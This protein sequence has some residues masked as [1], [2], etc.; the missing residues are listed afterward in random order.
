MSR[1]VLVVVVALGLGGCGSRGTQSGPPASQPASGPVRSAAACGADLKSDPL[2][3]GACGRVCPSADRTLPV[4]LKGECRQVC[5]V[6]YGECDGDPATVCETEVL[7]DPCHCFRC[8]A[9]CPAGQFC[10]AGVCQGHQD[11]LVRTGPPAP[12]S[13]VGWRMPPDGR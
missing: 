10:V 5:R 9:R 6:G 11:A 7:R 12:A 3:C 1:S 13:C 2:S 4:C 8:G